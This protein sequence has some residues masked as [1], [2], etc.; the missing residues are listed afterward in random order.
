MFDKVLI[1]NRGEIALRV[2]RACRDLGIASVAVYSTPDADAEFVK[3]AD[4]SV[5]IGPGPAAKSY[6]HVP[7]V[8][9]AALRTGFRSA[10]KELIFYT[11]G[12]AQYDVRELV[13]D[14]RRRV[15]AAVV[16]DDDF[17]VRRQLRGRLHGADHHAGD[18]AAVVVGREKNA[19]TR[20]FRSSDI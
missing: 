9:G 8:I 14:L 19:Q 11:D 20:W 6:L 3:A 17:V 2:V 5:H 13:D 16:D 1:A 7:N 18:R 10:T 12:D 15:S 4:E